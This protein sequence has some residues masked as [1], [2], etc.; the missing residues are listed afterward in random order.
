LI[1]AIFHPVVFFADHARRDFAR[2]DR[3]R[4]VDHALLLG[5]VAHFDIAGHREVLAERMADETV[6]GQDAAQVV[7]AFEHDAV[8][9]ERFALEPV[10]RVPD[11][12]PRQ[13]G[14]VVVR[15]EHA[16]A[17]APVVLDRQQ[18]RH[19]GKARPSQAPSP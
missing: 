17:H 18:V 11:R 5:V 8:Q 12:S 16:H 4:L 2:L 1:S 19:H 6:V 3:D 13:H 7:V 9:V 14:H 15:R 10:G